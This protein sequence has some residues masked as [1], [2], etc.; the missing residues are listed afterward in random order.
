MT[1]EPSATETASTGQLSALNINVGA[2]VT[3][4][5]ENK[6]LSMY[7]VAKA[8]KKLDHSWSKT[9]LFNIEHN[10]RRL[11]AVEAFDLLRCMGY[12]PETDLMLL[13]RDSPSQVDLSIED[14]AFAGHKCEV[15][16]SEYRKSRELAEAS[17]D[18]ATQA[19]TITKERADNLRINLRTW[20]QSFQELIQ[21][22]READGSDCH[23]LTADPEAGLQGYRPKC[24]S[25][26]ACVPLWRWAFLLFELYGRGTRGRPECVSGMA[27]QALRHNG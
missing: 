10:S 1:S 15:C 27:G 26:L 11:Q 24:V 19:G 21:E 2:N 7:D 18:E 17:L 22:N 8:M 6:H 16:W 5:R 13:Y 12:R 20:E 23:P 3:E 4:L 9:T 25:V 14:C